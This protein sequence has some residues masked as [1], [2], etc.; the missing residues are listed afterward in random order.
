M[1]HHGLPVRFFGETEAQRYARLRQVDLALQSESQGQV[2]E[3]MKTM[4]KIGSLEEERSMRN[5]SSSGTESDGQSEV[6]PKSPGDVPAIT[7]SLAVEE[8]DRCCDLIRLY[9]KAR[10][11][12][13]A[14]LAPINEQQSILHLWKEELKIRPDEIRTS[15]QGKLVAVQR[16][17][18]K[19]NIKNLFQ[20]LR[21]R[22]ITNDI[23]AH[24]ASICEY[25][26]LREYVKAND[27]YYLLSIGNAPWPLGVTA[28]GIHER[29]AREKIASSKVARK[30]PIHCRGHCFL[31]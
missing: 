2:N 16:E 23:L 1:R 4:E 17:Q 20:L 31:R 29:S 8:R 7:R 10:A 3:F 5:H 22:T 14:K 21:K 25:L 11:F 30:F 19:Q 6:K 9:L 15:T 18:T 12:I 26:R 28:V 13:G 24:L 27:A